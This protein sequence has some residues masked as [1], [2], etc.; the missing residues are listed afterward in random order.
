MELR[1]LTTICSFSLRK[2]LKISK[3]DVIKVGGQNFG[4]LNA[5]IF[6]F[7]FLKFEGLLITLTPKSAAFSKIIVFTIKE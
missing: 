6:S 3:S 2:L 5:N 7:K 1:G 4:K